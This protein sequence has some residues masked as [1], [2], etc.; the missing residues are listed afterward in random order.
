MKKIWK[1]YKYIAITVVTVFL[2]DLGVILGF[3]LYHPQIKKADAV[4]ILGAA[5]NTPA[6]YNRSMEG[7]KLYQEGKANML[8]LSGGQDFDRAITEARYMQNVIEANA[9]K[10]VPLILEDQSHSTYE[11][12]KNT[13]AKLRDHKSII[14]VSDSYHLAR[15]ALMAKRMGFGPVYW[16]SPRPDY[17]SKKELAFHYLREMAAMIDYIPKF[18]WN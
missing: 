8:V 17:Y 5:I 13:K 18:V 14:I 4:V 11:N 1:I 12:L 2:L 7:L 3:S 15:A 16:S 9:K 10:P 6:L